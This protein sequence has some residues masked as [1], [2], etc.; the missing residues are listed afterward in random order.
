MLELLQLNRCAVP[1][2]YSDIFSTA[3]KLNDFTFFQ[4][5]INRDKTARLP[6]LSKYVLAV[7]AKSA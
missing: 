4:V 6:M 2:G 7:V 5:S 3:E 1:D